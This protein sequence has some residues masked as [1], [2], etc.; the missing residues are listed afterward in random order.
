MRKSQAVPLR[1]WVPEV[2]PGWRM[3]V[4]GE[5]N[6]CVSRVLEPAREGRLG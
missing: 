1:G 2:E 6:V 5:L 4:A 3:D